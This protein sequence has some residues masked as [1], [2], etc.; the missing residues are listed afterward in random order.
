MQ[1][2]KLNL[3]VMMPLLMSCAISGQS[4]N[5]DGFCDKSSPIYAHKNDV[6]GPETSHKID[7]YND[8]GQAKCGWKPAQ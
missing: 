5:Y 3:L 2:T 8:Y 7:A 1:K 6:I 4:N